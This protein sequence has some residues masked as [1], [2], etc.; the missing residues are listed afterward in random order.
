MPRTLSH[1][2]EQMSGNS[3]FLKKNRESRLFSRFEAPRSYGYSAPPRTELHVHIS[4]PRGSQA[5]LPASLLQ[6]EQDRRCMLATRVG[7][8]ANAHQRIV[9][10]LAGWVDG[11]WS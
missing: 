6:W 8:R 10:L 7:G 3:G 1:H 9:Y 4:R 2:S 11:V 5:R